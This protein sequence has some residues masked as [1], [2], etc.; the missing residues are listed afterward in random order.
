MKIQV[1]VAVSAIFFLG[2]LW[3]V[4]HQ[5]S[6][7]T[8]RLA[9]EFSG[10]ITRVYSLESDR[11]QY[12]VAG[13]S[14]CSTLVTTLRLPEYA[15]G[16]RISVAGEV[17]PISDLPEEYVGYRDYLDRQA[18][19]GTV[20]LAD[21]EV[22]GGQLFIGERI[23]QSFR[24]QVET[25]FGQPEAGVMKAMLLGDRGTVSEEAQTAFE[26]TGTTHI[27]SISGLHVSILVIVLAFVLESLPLGPWVRSSIT[28]ALLWMYILLIGAPPAAV[29]AAL[30]CTCI[31]LALRLRVLVSLS[32]I[33]LL[34]AT[35]MISSNPHV[36]QDIGF[37]LSFSA[38]AG[39]GLVLF[40]V[41]RPQ[42]PLLNAFLISLGATIG[43]WPIV[44]YHFGQISLISLPANVLIVP[45]VAP[46]LI[47]ALLSILISFVVP[48]LGL[49]G[50]FFV[51]LLWKYIFSVALFMS[52]IPGAS[53]AFATPFWLAVGW[54]GVVVLGA[55]YTLSLQKRSWREIWVN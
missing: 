3:G 13:D 44:S 2:Y 37:Q 25:V 23:R 43:T 7:T 27:L 46:L 20:R 21:I 12:V 54:Y 16:Q 40:L 8:C 42:S 5:E 28:I 29:R 51:H 49:V 47:L 19:D 30:F 50:G 15:A 48:A 11:A 41:G 55:I 36:L 24:K 45:T 18:I 4:I 34:A 6:L 14:G 32:T 38:I 31:L 22:T 33:F 1:L 35:A 53:F 39:M 10:V 26:R 9:D 52:N 17:Q